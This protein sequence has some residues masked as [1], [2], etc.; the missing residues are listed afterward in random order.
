MLR[1]RKPH[2]EL[3]NKTPLE[4]QKIHEQSKLFRPFI[5]N[6]LHASIASPTMEKEKIYMKSAEKY[7]PFNSMVRHEQE[8]E[9][10]I[11]GPSI[12]VR[13]KGQPSRVKKEKL[14]A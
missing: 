4:L 12:V 5:S 14:S 13:R 2:R 10:Y 3:Q 11:E 8:I 7:L 6:T 9:P 1:I